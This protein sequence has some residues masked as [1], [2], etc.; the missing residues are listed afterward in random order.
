MY[1]SVLYSS[2]LPRC[3][4]YLIA[5]KQ[6]RVWQNKHY[7]IMRN[8]TLPPPRSACLDVCCAMLVFL[9]TNAT[10]QAGT[11]TYNSCSY[12]THLRT[13]ARDRSPT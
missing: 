2:A 6:K 4:Q 12:K 9:A 7:A 8:F 13:S 10:Q 1:S 11:A 3:T 5:A